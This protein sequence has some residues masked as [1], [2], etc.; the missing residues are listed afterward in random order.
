MINSVIPIEQRRSRRTGIITVHL[1]EVRSSREKRRTGG[2]YR[3]TLRVIRRNLRLEMLA[4]VS[5]RVVYVSLVPS[6]TMRKQLHL[7]AAIITVFAHSMT[8]QVSVSLRAALNL[9]A[10][11]SGTNL[12]DDL[13]DLSSPLR[14]RSILRWSSDASISF[15][16]LSSI[17]HPRVA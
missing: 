7:Y 3:R 10:E 15:S 1:V 12:E 16:S 11:E 6:P 9:H 2:A 14:L 4:R 8:L 13:S 17:L 5:I